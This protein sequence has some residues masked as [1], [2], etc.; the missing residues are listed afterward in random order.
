M[1]NSQHEFANYQ[2]GFDV[3]YQIEYAIGEESLILGDV[4]MWYF[5]QKGDTLE[6]VGLYFFGQTWTSNM[7]KGPNPALADVDPTGKLP[8]N[9]KIEIAA[10]REYFETF[11][12]RHL[13]ETKLEYTSQQNE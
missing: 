6:E 11:V 5:T 2:A 3:K 4:K 7:V 1:N 8:A 12:R 9:V 13:L 10:T